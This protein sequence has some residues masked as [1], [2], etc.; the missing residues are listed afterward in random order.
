M[1]IEI[2][3]FAGSAIIASAL[4]PQ[5]IKSWTTKSTEDISLLWNSLLLIGLILFIIYG[6]G[7][8]SRPIMIFT[9]IEAS[10][11]LSLLILKLTHSKR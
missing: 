7:L 11:T 10:L 2:V 3:G 6:I 8:H 9:T 1:D 4:V 5:V